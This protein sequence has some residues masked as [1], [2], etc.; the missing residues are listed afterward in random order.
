MRLPCLLGL[1]LFLGGCSG[2]I[3]ISS[4]GPP[5]PPPP[6]STVAVG[7]PGVYGNFNTNAGVVFG[8]A[9]LN[10]MGSGESEYV[11]RPWSTTRADPPLAEDRRIN[12]QDCTRPVDY[13]RGNLSCK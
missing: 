11:W 8:L 4:G 9:M 5:H 12:V 10:I 13:S 2:A 3:H 1:A 7:P 6:G